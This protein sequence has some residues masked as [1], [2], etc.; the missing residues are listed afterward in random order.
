MFSMLPVSEAR[1]MYGIVPDK[2]RPQTFGAARGGSECWVKTADPKRRR[3]GRRVG[4]FERTNGWMSG[5]VRKFC[6]PNQPHFVGFRGN[7]C[8]KL[9]SGVTEGKHR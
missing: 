7:R 1:T 4:W 9:P 6:H 5:K 2:Y 3:T 8:A